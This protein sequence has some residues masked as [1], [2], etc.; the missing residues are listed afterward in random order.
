MDEKGFLIG[1][2]QNT[3][4]IFARELYERGTLARAGQDGGREWITV[5]ATICA[6]GTRLAPALIYKAVSGTLQDTWISEFEPEEHA[7]HFAYRL[8]GGRVT[9]SAT[10]G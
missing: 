6:D 5:V 8:T 7:C 4:R 1:K 9:N 10:A 2:L 3:R